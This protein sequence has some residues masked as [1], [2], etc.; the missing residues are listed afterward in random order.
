MKKGE[1]IYL[2]LALSPE[3]WAIPQ[4]FPHLSF[5]KQP[6]RSECTDLTVD[7]SPLF[8]AVG[9]AQATALTVNTQRISPTKTSKAIGTA[10]SSLFFC[11][12]GPFSCVL[13]GAIT[14][15]LLVPCLSLSSLCCLYQWLHRGCFFLSSD[16]VPLPRE[17][18]EGFPTDVCESSSAFYTTATRKDILSLCHSNA[19]FIMVNI[20]VYSV[21]HPVLS[22]RAGCYFSLP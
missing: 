5:G 6:R 14:L 11:Q 12:C 15:L 8:P 22:P 10:K 20:M 7:T 19:A 17:P 16:S 1:R 4:L 9:E 13:E 2:L 21:E 3:R 18:W